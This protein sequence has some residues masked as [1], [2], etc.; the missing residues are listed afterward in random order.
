MKIQR[1]TSTNNSVQSNKMSTNRQS[2]M[3]NVNKNTVGD[4]VSFEK[5]P[6]KLPLIETKTTELLNKAHDLITAKEA[7]QYTE[8]CDSP[9]ILTRKSSAQPLAKQTPDATIK[10]ERGHNWEMSSILSVNKGQNNTKYFIFNPNK[11]KKLHVSV[12]NKDVSANYATPQG[13]IELNEEIR[14]NLSPLVGV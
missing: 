8:L 1:I 5:T 11:D 6:I 3:S 7:R 13:Q 2:Y 12:N 14:R 10:F 4:S 9:E